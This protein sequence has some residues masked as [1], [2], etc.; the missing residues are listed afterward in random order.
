MNREQNINRTIQGAAATG[1]LNYCRSQFKGA[2]S[3]LRISEFVAMI[4]A[5]RVYNP[6]F[7]KLDGLNENKL[8]IKVPESTMYNGKEVFFID[9][10]IVYQNIDGEEVQEFEIQTPEKEVT[11]NGNITAIAVQMQV[12]DVR[13]VELVFLDEEGLA[14][15]TKVKNTD[16]TLS[17]VANDL[18]GEEGDFHVNIL[19]RGNFGIS[20]TPPEDY[21]VVAWY[22]DDPGTEPISEGESM[23]G[24][25]HTKDF[26]AIL[27]VMRKLD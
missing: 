11:T 17:G 14:P 18:Q 10:N 5:E 15:V 25:Y 24:N 23:E 12:P 4:G 3:P 20:V 19:D 16:I 1:T 21:V 27:C 13:E 26:G 6:T 9:M 7:V 2:Y 8:K 22:Y